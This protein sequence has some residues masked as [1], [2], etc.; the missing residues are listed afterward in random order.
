MKVESLRNIS[1]GDGSPVEFLA[2]SPHL[3]VFDPLALDCL[4][5]HLLE[6]REQPPRETLLELLDKIELYSPFAYFHIPD[7]SPGLYQ[8]QVSDICK[9]GSEKDLPDEEW[10]RLGSDPDDID[11]DGLRW[12]GVDSGTIVIVDFDHLRK[13]T[14]LLTWQQASEGDNSVFLGI[15][16]ALGGPYF[17]LIMSPGEPFE[18]D[19]DGT[20]TLQKGA[21]KPIRR[22]A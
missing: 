7:F 12:F 11:P 17:A 1:W 3:V 18:F 4:R 2:D 13:L 21:F 5:Q 20:Y 15:A 6:M 14:E 16:N 19:G 8:L 10:E 9:F 22:M